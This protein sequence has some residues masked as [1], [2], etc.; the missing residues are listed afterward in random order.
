MVGSNLA[1]RMCSYPLE[2]LCGET[3]KR[4]LQERL[5]N[6]MTALL[7]SVWLD[8]QEHGSHWYLSS[9]NSDPTNELKLYILTTTLAV[10]SDLLLVDIPVT[11]SNTLPSQLH[12]QKHLVFRYPCTGIPEELTKHVAEMSWL[13]VYAKRSRKFH[14]WPHI[15]IMKVLIVSLINM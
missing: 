14:K 3:V 15:N 6:L 8:R 11:T 7:L 10:P 12:T 4:M 13:T 2:T 1:A 9:D 5:T